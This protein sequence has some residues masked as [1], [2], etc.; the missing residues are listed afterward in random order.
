M[1]QGN[2]TTCMGYYSPS[3]YKY[4][5]SDLMTQS[6]NDNDI[7]INDSILHHIENI[8]LIPSNISLAVID[9]AL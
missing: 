3:E 7:K 5:L 1:P 6:I 8:D 9:N 2:L 4:T